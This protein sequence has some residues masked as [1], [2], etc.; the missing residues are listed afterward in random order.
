MLERI[1]SRF[2][3]LIPVRNSDLVRTILVS[4]I[5]KVLNVVV[6][7]VLIRITLSYLG[8]ND[9]GFWMVL[10]TIFT[11]FNIF[12]FGLGNGLRNK[13]TQSLSDHDY[14]SAKQYVSTTYLALTSIFTFIFLT[15]FVVWP[16]IDW[17]WVF[18]VTSIPKETV[19]LI[20]LVTLAM[21]CL[22]LVTNLLTSILLAIHKADS[23]ELINLIINTITLFSVLIVKWVQPISILFITTFLYGFIPVLVL[24]AASLY[25]FKK[26]VRIRPGTRHIKQEA[27]SALKGLGSQFFVLQICSMIFV[28]A[29]SFII[30]HL[31]STTEVTTYTI[32]Y[33]YLSLLIVLS[34][35]II[36]PYWSRITEAAHLSDFGWIRKAVLSL[37]TLWLLGCLIATCLVLV[38]DWF[39]DLWLG[40]DNPKAPWVLTLVTAI[41]VMVMIFNT[42]FSTVLNAISK[43]RLQL[44]LGVLV[45]GLSIP[46][47]IIITKQFNFGLV[48]IP[49]TL[50]LC[51]LPT[52]ILQPLQYFK[53]I[54]GQARGIWDQ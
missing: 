30:A 6:Q 46:L 10:S 19:N 41:S 39:F 18:N 53:V 44:F 12:D 32:V 45:A 17:N 3:S 11:S 23:V 20:T 51:M 29:P 47:M 14:V 26:D 54:K 15:G 21:F 25:I 24:I 35:V 38:S 2:I 22:R 49:L 42:I 5:Y 31:F 9:Y 40:E 52:L 27:L 16:F 36:V 37:I 8:S 28:T 7:F 43:I 33:R 4:V 13:L 34:N 48:T 50:I 1:W